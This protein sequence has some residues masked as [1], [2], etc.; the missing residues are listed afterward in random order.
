MVSSVNL[1][2]RA[3]GSW[4][5]VKDLAGVWLL[6]ILCDNRHEGNGSVVIEAVYGGLFV[7]GDDGGRFKA[8]WNRGIEQGE[9]EQF[10]EDTSQLT[11]TLLDSDS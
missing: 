11:R 3:E 8:A 1:L 2:E 6:Q 10:G 9:V 7:D 4:E 5:T